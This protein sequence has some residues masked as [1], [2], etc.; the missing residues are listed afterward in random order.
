MAYPYH[1]TFPRSQ[2]LILGP[3]SIQSLLPVTPISQAEALLESHRI[4]DAILLA[5]QQRKKVQGKLVADANEVCLFSF[6]SR[7]SVLYLIL[8]SSRQ[9][10]L[11]T[12]TRKSASNACSRGASRMPDF[13]SSRESS[14]LAYSSHTFPTSAAR[15][16]TRIQRLT[17]FLAL[18]SACRPT[19]RSTTLV[20]PL[21]PTPPATLP[22]HLHNHND[23]PPL[24]LAANIQS[25]P[26]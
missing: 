5:D 9:T 18:P 21:F 15:S 14:T 16:S 4:E 12:S 22:L 7:S 24:L 13:A 8:N 10:N 26:T 3:N 17:S 11:H 25:W 20:R 6:L 1:S 2:L 19:T 23:T